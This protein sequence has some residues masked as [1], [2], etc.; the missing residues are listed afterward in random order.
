MNTLSKRLSGKQTGEVIL[1]PILLLC[2]SLGSPARW[3]VLKIRSDPFFPQA[4]SPFLPSQPGTEHSTGLHKYR[5]SEGNEETLNFRSKSPG[6][7]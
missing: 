4:P 6:F 2:V 3:K 7:E 1:I 5:G